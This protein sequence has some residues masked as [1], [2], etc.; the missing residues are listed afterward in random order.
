MH[1]VIQAGGK[2]TRLEGLTHNRPKCIVPVNNRP[3]IFWAFEAFK[4]HE[5]TVICDYK[6]EALTRYLAS[7]GRQYKVKVIAAGGTGTASGIGAAVSTIEDDEPIAVVWC[8]LLFSSDWQLPEFLQQPK[9][10]GNYVGLS[11]S[12]P[13]RWS[14]EEGH[15]KHVAS[16]SKGVAGFF[17]FKNKK[18]LEQVPTDGALVPWLMASGI[19]FEPFYLEGITEVGTVKAFETFN[20]PAVCRPFNEVLFNEETVQKRGI[21]EQGRKIAID[22]VAWYRHVSA[23]GFSSIPKIL[24]YEPLIMERIKGRNIWEYDCLTFSEKK[25]VINSIIT[26]L[27]SLHSLEPTC[28]AITSDL[29]ENYINKTFSRLE[30][31]EDL[32]PFAKDEYIKIN[33]RYYKNIFFD[34]EALA[35]TL[36]KYYPREFHLIHGDPT[37]SNM[38]YDRIHGNVFFID[39]RGYFGKTKL[40]GD[41]D[42]DWAKVYY[43]LVGNYDQFNRKK[44]ALSIN[45]KDVELAVKS[46]N[47]EDM[48]EYF[49]DHLDGVSKTKIKALH[50]VIWLSLTTYTW[51]DYDSICGAFYNGILKSADFL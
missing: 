1:V 10:D 40:Y 42:Y 18:E 24:S 51:E 8:D 37:F 11:G 5:I 9:L 14:F 44:F 39:P 23:L 7:F 21:D 31:V 43:S 16:S 48:D 4:E 27:K 49:F 38:V 17:V 45:K 34:R 46:S 15:F 29:E 13:C 20:K 50:A 25:Q 47:W 6:Q 22:E 2:G 30:K 19:A 35:I 26:G 3:M 33:G 28:P 12:F 36:R 41:T 32:V